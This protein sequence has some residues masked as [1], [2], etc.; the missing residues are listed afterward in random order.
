MEKI[1]TEL[2]DILGI[3][4]PIML[5]GMANVATGELV[6]AVSNAGGIGVLGCTYKTHEWMRKEIRKIKSLTDKPFGADIIMPAG[7][8][9]DEKNIE[10]PQKHL[11]FVNKLKREFNIPDYKK[12]KWPILTDEFVKGQVEI[13]LEEKVNLFVSGLGSPPN[14]MIPRAHGQGMKVAG[15]VGNVK[16]AKKV[17]ASGVDFVIAT[18]HEAGGHVSRVGTLALIPQVVDAI[19]IPVVAGGGIGDSRGLVAALALGAVG[20]WLGTAFMAA[21][22]A[23]PVYRKK[24]LEATDDSTVITK[25]YSGKTMRVLP[26]KW[27]EAWQKSA[28]APLPM[29]LQMALVRDLRQASFDAE[30]LDVMAVSMGQIAGMFSEEKS[31]RELIE[32]IILG[33]NNIIKK[34]LGEK[35]RLA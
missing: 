13:I 11:D 7:I 20:V 29:H 8:P 27:T 3:Q 17:A 31:A 1:R 16:S 34:S 28:I 22:E 32:E 10:L 26:N 24:L 30:M 6:A 14:W 33:A 12:D 18:G 4:Y 2:C 23:P 21:K 9:P 19:R 5:A 35:I 15:V 25:S